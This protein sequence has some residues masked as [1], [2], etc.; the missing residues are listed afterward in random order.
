VYCKKYIPGENQIPADLGGDLYRG[1]N[2]QS[3]KLEGA[4]IAQFTLE[5]AKLGRETAA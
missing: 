1:V 4:E 2:N 5:R 3:V